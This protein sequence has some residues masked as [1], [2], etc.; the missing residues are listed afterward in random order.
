MDNLIYLAIIVLSLI[1]FGVAFNIRRKKALQKPMV[2]PLNMKCEQVLFSKYAKFLG[3]PLEILGLFYYGTLT[4][5]YS[6]FLFY[7]SLKNPFFVFSIFILSACGFLFSMY[8]VSLQAFK[9]K[10][11]CSW[12]LM[13]A[14]ISTT[15]FLLALQI[16]YIS[17]TLA[18]LA[19]SYQS[20]IFILYS[21]ATS[22]GLGL[23]VSLEIL[24][25][26]FLGD[27]RI[28]NQESQ[29]LHTLRQMTWLALGIM[30][31]SN[32]ALYLIDPLIM[33]ISAK[34]L[35]KVIIMAVLVVTTL[36]YDLFISSKLVDI[37]SDE[38][39]RQ[40]IADKYLRNAPFF[41]GPVTL[42]SWLCIFILEMTRDPQM[43]AL[44]LIFLY[45]IAL[46]ISIIGGRMLNIK[47]LKRT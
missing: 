20:L 3:I 24:F 39:N 26:R 14:A 18:S 23:S 10:E 31:V 8:L 1:G 38:V 15:N 34:F 44:K 4:F 46:M 5:S 36:I 16:Q 13:S 30:V 43:Q 17:S 2:C 45:G 35:V 22:L 12:C 33:T 42:A 25:L 7:P 47:I 6:I 41:F 28:S 11:W 29:I 37:Y 27:L 32:Y 21:L 9:L 40:H 19:D